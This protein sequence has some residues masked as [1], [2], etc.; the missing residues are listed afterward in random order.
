MKL[1]LMKRRD[2]D[3]RGFEGSPRLESRHG[4]FTSDIVS[5]HHYPASQGYLYP[6]LAYTEIPPV[7]INPVLK[8]RKETGTK[9]SAPRK[10]HKLH[11]G[12]LLS[13][14]RKCL[15]NRMTSSVKRKEMCFSF[16]LPAVEVVMIVSKSTAVW[17]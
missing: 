16:V 2:T 10:L 9:V 1:Q 12:D 14:E 17:V 6:L 13:M 7:E 15:N 8:K 5:P 11:F 3:G 4:G